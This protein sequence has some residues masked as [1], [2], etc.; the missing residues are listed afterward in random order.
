MAWTCNESFFVSFSQLWAVNYC[1]IWIP[2]GIYFCLISTLKC[3]R[4]SSGLTPPSLCEYFGESS[5]RCLGLNCK[6]CATKMDGTTKDGMK[7]W[8]NTPCSPV[9][10]FSILSAHY[11]EKMN[12]RGYLFGGRVVVFKRVWGGQPTLYLE[13]YF[14]LI[15]NRFDVYD[16]IVTSHEFFVFILI[17]INRGDPDLYIGTKY[18]TI[19]T[20]IIENLWRDATPPPN[21]LVR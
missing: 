6:A 5:D 18:S 16:V 12:Y 14:L 21:S 3:F 1:K 4:W 10:C 17:D 20:L 19:W 13:K 11:S 9:N 15:P 7:N 8:K 2:H